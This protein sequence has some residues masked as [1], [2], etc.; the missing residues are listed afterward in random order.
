MHLDTEVVDVL[1]RSS[2]SGNQLKLPGQ[3]DRKL[4]VKVAKAIECAGGKWDRR[5]GSHLFEGPAEEAL[6]ILQGGSVVNQKSELG[7]FPTPDEVVGAMICWACI[8]PGDK[9]LEPSAGKGNIVRAVS[10]LC[11]SVTAVEI[12]HQHI[13]DLKKIAG[14]LDE[15]IEGDFLQIEPKPIFDRVVMN[16][17]FADLT[18]PRHILHALKFLKPKGGR[19]VSICPAS[20]E[21]RKTKLFNELRSF[22]EDHDGDILP[23]KEGSF[24]ESGTDVRTCIIGV[25]L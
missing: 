16:P 8:R 15:I 7:Y 12:D 21:F 9:V 1:K 3:L 11:K 22:V 18:A 4:Y 23:L 25:S 5:S 17:P 24:H 6:R 19:L 10:R 2:A 13:A 14:P 20:I